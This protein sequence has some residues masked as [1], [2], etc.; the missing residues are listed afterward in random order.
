ME[1]NPEDN[2]DFEKNNPKYNNEN[3]L[4]VKIELNKTCYFKGE[5]LK[6][7]ITLKT[8]DIVKKSLLLIPIIANA[9]LIEEQ[10]YKY[11]VK[12]FETSEEEILFK[13]PMNV[14]KFDGKK[15]IEGMEIPFQYEIPQNS[16][17]SCIF[18]EYSYVRH[19]L[20]FDF[21]SIGVRKS[22]II[23]IKNSQYYSNYNEL[24]KSPIEV[25]FKKDKH[26]YALLYMGNFTAS[27]KLEKNAYAYDEAIPL[28]IDID[29]SSLK[30]SLQTIHIMIF[31]TLSKNN[32]I[33]H[34]QPNYKSEK[35]VFSKIITLLNKKDKY[36]LEDLI[37]LSK[38]NPSDIYK[39]LDSDE[40]CY[41]EKFKGVTLYPS[42]YKGLLSCEYYMKVT[43]ETDTLF[44]TNES[45]FIPIDFYESKDLE[46][47]NVENIYPNNLPNNLEGV[48]TPIPLSNLNDNT[49]YN[50]SL[51]Q[52]KD[53]PKNILERNKTF[54]EKKNN[55]NIKPVNNKENKINNNDNYIKNEMVTAEKEIESYDAP[56][57]IIQ[58]GEKK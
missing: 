36:H 51:T 49:S 43:F 26:K 15:L 55:L 28:Q 10:K 34:S 56:P 22:T 24:Y 38:G 39:Q 58:D 3:D 31:L 2:N 50:R 4:L 23:I 47:K 37:T 46:N 21:S 6:G 27:V 13:F 45:L 33:D 25:S 8:K 19:V 9:T 52:I 30:I 54:E 29:C 11:S 16:Y 41:S 42:C 32:K 12:G 1:N 14:P 7:T 53:K 40:R 18:D 20:I 48:I 57:S 44:S 17:P 35:K 5:T